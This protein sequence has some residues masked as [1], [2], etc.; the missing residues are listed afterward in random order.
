MSTKVAING[1][2]R[3]GRAVLKLVIDEPSI[4][5]VA[6]N[7]PNKYAA[8]LAGSD[9]QTNPAATNEAGQRQDKPYVRV[10][11]KRSALSTASHS[12]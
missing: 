5:L 6:S 11:A 4:E 7:P 12:R 10:A 8:A 9:I 2:G 1:L 3:I